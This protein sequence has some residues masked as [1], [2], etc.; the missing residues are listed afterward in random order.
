MKKDSQDKKNKDF[1]LQDNR[2]S[3]A[4]NLNHSEPNSNKSVFEQSGK[5]KKEQSSYTP[6]DSK[7]YHP[8]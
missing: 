5:D 8:K 2:I 1:N 4:K 7:I 3:S 6:K